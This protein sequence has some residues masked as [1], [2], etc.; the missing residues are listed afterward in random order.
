MSL[1]NHSNKNVLVF[2]IPFSRHVDLLLN[3][4]KDQTLNPNPGLDPLKTYIF[5]PQHLSPE[6]RAK[7]KI[8]VNDIAYIEFTCILITCFLF[9]KLILF[10]TT[11]RP[12]GK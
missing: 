6:I 8:S 11:L 7:N 5:L 9:Q 2:S 4:I 12:Q 10:L 1:Y 3:L